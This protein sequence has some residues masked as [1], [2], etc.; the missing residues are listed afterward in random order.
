[1]RAIP[2]L[3]VQLLGT[4]MTAAPV[5]ITEAA[6]STRLTG[7]NDDRN[8]ALRVWIYVSGSLDPAGRAASQAVADSLLHTAGVAVEWRTCEPKDACSRQTDPSPNVTLILTS[9]MRPRCGTAALERGGMSATVLISVPCIAQVVLE[10]TRGP[11]ARSNP[12]LATLEAHHVIGAAMAHELGHVLG[13]RHA[14]S[15][16]MRA[17]LDLDD[18]LALRRGELAFRPTEVAAMRASTMWQGLLAA[19]RADR[20]SPR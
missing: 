19:G 2:F 17:R 18:I 16:I 5:A 3:L 7:T 13:L 9:A 1:M 8:G 10:A 11:L 14:R 20:P 15:G 4:T 12:L 6:A